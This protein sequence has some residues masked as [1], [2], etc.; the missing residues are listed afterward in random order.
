VIRVIETSSNLATRTVVNAYDS[1]YPDLEAGVF[2]ARDPA[3]FVDG[4]NVYTYVRQ[5]PWTMFDPLGLSPA[6]ADPRSLP[7]CDPGMRVAL[8]QK[9]REMAS[10]TSDKITVGVLQVIGG[11][12][13]YLGDVMDGY[14]VVKPLENASFGSIR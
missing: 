10:A 6:W 8:D 14:D 3:G 11:F 9:D 13:P 12:V 5:N 2:V 1:A 4:P 7:N